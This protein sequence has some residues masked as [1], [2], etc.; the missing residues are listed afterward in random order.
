MFNSR[1]GFLLIT[2]SLLGNFIIS[3]CSQKQVTL[4]T[5]LAEMGNRQAL[6]YFPDPPYSLKQVSSHNPAS[7]SPDSAG[8]FTNFDRSNF[9]RVENNQG[10]RE[11][12]LFDENG[13]GAI[14]RW[15]MTFYKA[16]YGILRI[17]FDRDSVP[18]I[19]GSPK[20]LLSGNLLA[21][22]PFSAS[23]QEGAPLGE[24]GRD[25]DHNLYLPLPFS[26]HAK[27]TYE[28][29]SLIKKYEYEG[30]SVPG[31][32]YWPDVFYNICYSKYDP[33]V[34]VKTLSHEDLENARAQ[35]E[36][37][38]S[39]LLNSPVPASKT[40]NFKQALMP[41]DSILLRVN[42]P[43]SAISGITLHLDAANHSQALRSTI[44]SVR[45]DGIPTVWV[46]VGEFFG[47]GT[48]VSSHKT[49]MN[50]SDVSGKM[51]SWWIM[52]Y[53]K[54][55]VV[56][57]INFGDQTV[58][59]T[60]QI[61]SCDYQW[62]EN[63]M[64]FGAAWHEYRHLRTRDENGEHFDINFI[65]IKGKG[66]YAADQ[67]TLFNTTYQW[68][69]EGDEKIFV[70]GEAFPSSFGT[71]SED[72]YGYSFGRPDPFSHPFIAQPVGKGNTS[73]GLTV[74]MRQRSLDAIPF[75]TAIKPDIELW[76]WAD[77]YINYALTSFW[78]S[79]APFTTNIKPDIQSVRYPVTTK[80][81]DIT[82]N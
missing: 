32:F 57:F 12:V 44:L 4:D 79:K 36:A 49:W 6:T 70:D 40:E 28:C 30:I 7:V 11:F 78:Y 55:A 25:Y 21:G 23:V 81:E 60:G 37:T 64:Y 63:S 74:N 43:G 38:K 29:D 75:V 33:A 47:T 73:S 52:P 80:K 27:I 26:G 68:W 10:R 14:V 45:F 8:W 67:V 35:L 34:S 65:A 31:G 22:Y 20:E 39:E 54:E 41:G 3:G 51:A 5:L 42:D 76:H 2:L 59:L 48:M 15:W 46:P 71:G 58:R 1:S 18:F 62:E 56:K 66:I 50:F 77:V 53:K 69:G 13:P 16:Q 24:E 82:G 72:Y 17:Y 61:S 19:E 9:I